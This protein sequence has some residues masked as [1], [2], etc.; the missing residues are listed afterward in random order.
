MVSNKTFEQRVG[1]LMT[2]KT[3]RSEIVD[4]VNKEGLRTS[5]GKKVT[6]AHVNYIANK[7]GG[8]GGSGKKSG[9]KGPKG[10]KCTFGQVL[11]AVN[12]LNSL[13]EIDR[14]EALRLLQA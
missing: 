11:G 7:K 10:P 6:I 12:L 3:P 5:R 1:E 8:A 2:K 4:T 9:K 14:R 13:P